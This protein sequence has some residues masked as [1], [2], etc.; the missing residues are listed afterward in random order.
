M[1]AVWNDAINNFPYYPHQLSSH[2]QMH[3][4]NGFASSAYISKNQNPARAN[5]NNA[6]SSV[7]VWAYEQTLSEQIEYEWNECDN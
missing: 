4:E 1:N 2:F 3:T 7:W 5:A 6:M